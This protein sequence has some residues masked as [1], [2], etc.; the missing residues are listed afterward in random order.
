VH[1]GKP[2]VNGQLEIPGVAGTGAPIRLDFLNP[3]GA[4]TGK[5][6]P[7]GNLQDELDYSIHW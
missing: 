1:N 5:L 6:F 7:T 4:T 2:L 3:G